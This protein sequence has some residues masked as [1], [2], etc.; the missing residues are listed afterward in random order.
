MALKRNAEC[1]GSGRWTNASFNVSAIRFSVAYAA[2]MISASRRSSTAL[3]R[4]RLQA[5]GEFGL[6]AREQQRDDQ[7][8]HDRESNEQTDAVGRRAHL[9]S[10]S[11]LVAVR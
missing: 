11:N 8:Q 5:R 6:P 1:A 7:H 9:F 3:S 10:G 4:S 2:R